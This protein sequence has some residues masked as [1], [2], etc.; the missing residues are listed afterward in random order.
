MYKND[1]KEVILFN[2]SQDDLPCVKCLKQVG[3]YSAMFRDQFL[4]KSLIKETL[5]EVLR[6]LCLA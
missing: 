3:R 4:F 1:V 5:N 2:P 6:S